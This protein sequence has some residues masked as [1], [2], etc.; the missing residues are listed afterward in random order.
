MKLYTPLIRHWCK[1]PGGGTLTRQDRQDITQE[2]LRKVSQSVGEFDEQREGRSLRAWLRTI[3]ANAIADHLEFVEK[4]RGVNH[5]MS[6]TGHFKY[7][8]QKPIELEI[9]EE[10]ET[11]KILL[12]RQILKIVEPEFSKRDFEIVGLFVNAEKTSAEVAE[13]MDM[14][15]DT[16]RRIKNRILVRIRQEYDSLGLSDEMPTGK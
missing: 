15:P 4:R 11:E 1:K 9:E 2:V 6:D 8:S 5:L 13:I 12:L 16:V 10:P 14:K 7:P 3:T